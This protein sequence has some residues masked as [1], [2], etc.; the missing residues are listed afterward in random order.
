MEEL[1]LLLKDIPAT[2]D[3]FIYAVLDY[4][5]YK[6]DHIDMIIE[7][8]NESKDLTTSSVI[9]FIMNQP[10]F[11]EYCIQTNSKVS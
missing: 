4:A 7:F 6:S 3:D 11:K 1:S 8:I 2:Y 5:K 9:E 10:D